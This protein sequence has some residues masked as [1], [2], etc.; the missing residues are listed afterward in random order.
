M[1]RKA[2][3]AVEA[4]VKYSGAQAD[5]AE[6]RESRPD[7]IH[8]NVPEALKAKAVAVE[9]MD[10]LYVLNQP[11]QEETVTLTGPNPRANITD[12]NGVRFVNG[13]AEGVPKSLAERYEREFDGYSVG[14]SKSGKS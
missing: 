11:E 3:N 14:G 7:A 6:A 4:V 8:E 9:A 5:E 2:K 10:E 12:T 1:A 13:K